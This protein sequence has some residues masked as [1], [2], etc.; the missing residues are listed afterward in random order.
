MAG[1]KPNLGFQT[2]ALDA[3]YVVHELGLFGDRG[4]G[5][6]GLILADYAINVQEHPDPKT[7]KILPGPC[8]PWKGILFRRHYK[9]FET[10]VERSKE[11]FYGLF[12]NRD[13]GGRAKYLEGDK[14]WVFYDERGRPYPDVFLIFF[15]MEHDSDV[16]SQVGQEWN[17]V[18]FDELPHW[19]NKKP[20][21][22]MFASIRSAKPG[23]PCRMRSTGNP[24]AAGIGWIKQHFGIPD[25]PKEIVKKKSCVPMIWKDPRSGKELVRMFLLSLREENIPL[26]QNDPL[27][28]ARLAASVEGDPDLEKAW[29]DSD[30][31]ALFGQYF[32][33]FSPEIHRRNV[34]DVFP[35]G[36][37]PPFWKLYGHLD[38]GENAPT[39]FGLW[40]VD[41]DYN[42]YMIE[43][44]Y[45]AGE[46]V[47]YHAGAIKDIVLSCSLTNGRMPQITFADSQI[48]HTR[49]AENVTARNRTIAKIF[50]NE[51]GLK[52]RP[53]IK[54]AGSRVRGWRY[55]K[56]CLSYV[57]DDKGEMIK[58]PSIYYLSHCT[59]WEREVQN[60][61]FSETGDKEDIDKR[62][63]DHHLT[64]TIYFLGGSQKA[65]LPQKEQT[66]EASYAT[67]EY[68]KQQEQNRKFGRRIETF[69]VPDNRPKKMEDVL[70]KIL[71]A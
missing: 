56:Q 17:W 16:E 37:V 5:K 33:V 47:G 29:L 21:L 63:D 7:G 32:K 39:A 28:D 35:D 23:I 70:N 43:D 26:R 10:I 57:I 54:G 71:V 50:E 4:G 44:Y 48:W 27:Y 58:K 3:R 6:T 2:I 49:S 53:S 12:G 34:E 22:K 51:T 61:V 19:P 38:Y 13:E 18:A 60:A 66:P 11:V 68:Y 1:W 14:K 69:M 52:L 20:Y 36:R 15:H 65:M 31:S 41:P 25:G 64:G 8:R 46:W 24:G 42:K 59:N 30:F 9:E 40:A 67:V 62:C 45:Q 55:F